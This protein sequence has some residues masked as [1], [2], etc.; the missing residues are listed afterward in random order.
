[1]L[2]ISKSIELLEES[3][4]QAL[5]DNEIPEGK[6]IDYKEALHSNSD[7][8]KKEFLY[9]ISSF[10]NASG[11][12]LI[13]GIKENGGVPTDIYGLDISDA[14]DVILKLENSIRDGI[15][16][17]IPG[18]AA[19]A[20]SLSNNRFIIVFRIP[21]S[22]SQPHMTAFKNASKFYSR[23]SAGKYQLDVGELKTA[24]TL[25]QNATDRIRSFRHQR[26]EIISSGETPITMNSGAKIVLHVI[27]I[28]AFAPAHNFDVV[29]LQQQNPSPLSGTGWDCKYNFDGF[30]CFQNDLYS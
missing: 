20:I 26:L 5:L 13:F 3:D 16:P 24:F 8:D 17:R 2:F 28:D 6:T 12:H 15:V 7:N 29:S 14:D 23:N 4:I 9:D 10:A 11:G 30:L 19:R 18:I 25:S 21:R 27:P 1:M 22:F